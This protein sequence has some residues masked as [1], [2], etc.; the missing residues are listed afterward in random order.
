MYQVCWIRKA[1]LVFGSTTFA[2]STVLA[3]FFLGLAMG[4]HLF[5]RLAQRAE[6]PLRLFAILEVTLGLF[7]L[8]SPLVFQ[9]ADALYGRMYRAAPDTP[10]LLGIARAGLLGLAIAP[11]TT[12]MGGTLPLFCRRYAAGTLPMTRSVGFL[13]GLNTL[14][15]AAGAAAV[16][17]VMLPWLGLGLTT[18]AAAG[19][20]IC[21]GAAV[22]LL[23][24]SREPVAATSRP[25]RGNPRTGDTSLALLLYFGVGFV[26]LGLEVVWFRFLS[27]IIRNTVYTYTLVLTIVLVGIVLGSWLAAR[28]VSREARCGQIFGALQLLSAV[29]VIGLM[30]L[31]PDV[32]RG[33][34]NDLWIC[35]LLLLVPS[36]LGGASFPLAVRLVAGDSSSAALGAGLAAA[37]NTLGGVLG[38]LLLGFAVLPYWGLQAAV[39]LTTAL[40]L[41]IGSA[42]LLW[43]DA[44]TLSPSRPRA[45][46]VMAAWSVWLGLVVFGHTRLPADYLAEGAGRLVDYREG[47]GANL[48]VFE[49]EGVTRLEIDRWWQ[50]EN[51]R[52]HQAL[53][54]HIP[55]TLHPEAR[56]VL[57]V[58]VG[59]GQT[60]SRFLMHDIAR[61]DCV[62]IEPALFDFVRRHFDSAWMTDPR[63]RVIVE[64][65]RTYLRHGSRQY[66]IISLELGQPFRPGVAYFYTRE[67]YEF[68]RRRLTRDG[69]V[70]QFVPLTFFTPEQFRALVGTFLDVFPQSILWYNTSELLLIGA[71]AP[72]FPWRGNLSAARSWSAAVSQDLDFAYWG[73]PAESLN[74]MEVFLGGFLMGPDALARLADSTEILRDDLPVLDY[75]TARVDLLPG[76]EV[77]NAE[78]LRDRLSPLPAALSSG[79]EPSVQ[80]RVAHIQA[81]NVGDIAAAALIKQGA[82][83]DERGDLQG[84]TSALREALRWNDEDAQANPFMGDVLLRQD[85]PEQALP[86]FAAAARILPGDA[87][88]QHG[89]A[90]CLHRTGRVAEAIEYYQRAV[91]LDAANPELHNNMG[92]ALAELGRYEEARTHFQE[93]LRLRPGYA[94]AVRNLGTLPVGRN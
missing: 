21:G 69:L 43:L 16:G 24:V 15:A 63:T 73:G 14:G 55:T 32:W 77:A 28:L 38:A 18:Q 8:A 4:S 20:S 13:Y 75:A 62:D 91:A 45:F 33:L 56:A 78:V 3:V 31:P 76:N 39:R 47:F 64:D 25:A 90:M 57:L 70:V 53:S 93:A 68:A 40:G 11:A 10:W 59:T 17:F 58:G 81:R 7:A 86:Y 79:L 9:A 72:Q 35:A 54:A 6:R 85:Q 60:A 74:R 5:G 66:D 22:A 19:L 2:V 42:G 48:A 44:G 80:R 61:L 1:S 88:A 87:D 51:R 67:A 29:S 30:M 82:G 37:V 94:D 84:A 92:A 27:L 41:V 12:L 23:P 71:N 65:G 50:G 49:Q 36:V 52:T 89:T 46:G 34:E 83:L 26:A